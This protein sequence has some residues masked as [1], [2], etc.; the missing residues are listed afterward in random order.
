VDGALREECLRRKET[1]AT[2]V[3]AERRLRVRRI[4]RRVE[5]GSASS[6]YTHVGMILFGL[7]I[8][9]ISVLE[10][11]T[12]VDKDREACYLLA[13]YEDTGVTREDESL[14]V[15]VLVSAHE[16]TCPFS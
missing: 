12:S 13:T 4:Q 1:R 6:C 14:H 5:P 11:Q 15:R 8:A 2:G 10:S 9:W 16:R 7:W 3:K